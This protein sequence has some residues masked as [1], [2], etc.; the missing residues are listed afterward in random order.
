MPIDCGYPDCDNCMFDDC[1][2]DQNDIHALLK[3]R[4][5]N[6]NIEAER[7]KQRNYRNRIRACLPCCDKCNL[8]ILVEKEKQDGYRRLCIKDLRLIEQKVSNCPRWCYKR[9]SQKKLT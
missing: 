9:K 5:Y 8:C 6:N 2:M 7:Q 4:R 1:I 3:R